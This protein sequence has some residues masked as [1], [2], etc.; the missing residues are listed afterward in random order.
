MTRAANRMWSGASARRP[1]VAGPRASSGRCAQASKNSDRRRKRGVSQAWNAP[2]REIRRLHSA[3]IGGLACASPSRT[4]PVDSRRCVARME[5]GG[6]NARRNGSKTANAVLALFAAAGSPMDRVGF[7][8]GQFF[9]LQPFT[10]FSTENFVR[11]TV[12]VRDFAVIKCVES[13]QR[14]F[15]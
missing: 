2:S 12:L 10:D 14:A 15:A 1:T 13:L 4:R 5:N 3:S 7:Y 9:L 6:V 8:L 11:Q